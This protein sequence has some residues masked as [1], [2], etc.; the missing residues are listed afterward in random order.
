MR[1]VKITSVDSTERSSTFGQGCAASM[2]IGKHQIQTGEVI[3]VEGMDELAFG[4]VVVQTV[5]CEVVCVCFG[6][7]NLREMLCFSLTNCYFY[8]RRTKG[9]YANCLS[10]KSSRGSP[11]SPAR[12]RCLLEV[13]LRRSSLPVRER[14]S[15]N[16]IPLISLA[17]VD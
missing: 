12:A 11:L 15:G 13:Y 2:S 3:V 7:I 16:E 10:Q 9:K 6:I 17:R 1:P 8:K 4:L 5:R 14:Q